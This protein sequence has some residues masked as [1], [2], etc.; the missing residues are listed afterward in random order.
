MRAKTKTGQENVSGTSFYYQIAFRGDT[1]SDT[2]YIPKAID[3]LKCDG[4]SL[5]RYESIDL[6]KAAGYVFSWS[7]SLDADRYHVYVSAEFLILKHSSRHMPGIT[8]RYL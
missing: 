8:R 1:L 5:F 2:L 4:V 6:P 3:S 7:R